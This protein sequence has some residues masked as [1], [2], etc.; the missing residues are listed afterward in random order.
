MVMSIN[1][2]GMSSPKQ[3]QPADMCAEKKC[4]VL[5]IQETHRGE[6]AVRPRIRGMRLVAK[7]PHKQYGSDIFVRSDYIYDLTS[8]STIN[9]VEIIHAQ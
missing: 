7:I 3:R 1:I 2:D 4:D 6:K 9:N 5:C 8:T